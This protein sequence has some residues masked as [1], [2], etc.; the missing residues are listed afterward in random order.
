MAGRQLQSRRSGKLSRKNKT[1][2]KTKNTT[3]KTTQRSSKRK[4]KRL[5]EIRT[6]G[7]SAEIIA[8]TADTANTAIPSAPPMPSDLASESGYIRLPDVST[9]SYAPGPL[10]STLPSSS[11]L[12][13]EAVQLLMNLERLYN[14]SSRKVKD[15]V[16]TTTVPDGAKATDGYQ[17]VPK[18]EVKSLDG[19]TI[20]T[21]ITRHEDT[22]DGVI[23]HVYQRLANN[24]VFQRFE[25]LVKGDDTGPV[26]QNS[27][28]NA[29]YTWRPEDGT[30]TLMH[31]IPMPQ[32]ADYA[33]VAKAFDR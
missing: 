31:E 30:R 14:S 20:N 2:R 13:P 26:A 11:I 17:A 24:Q 16:S 12:S 18:Q 5:P 1:P 22:P 29:L 9:D 19:T 25:Y 3:R 10:I 32:R 8:N 6:T 33:Q 23:W 27:Q 21:Y 4:T 7:G 15:F 28:N